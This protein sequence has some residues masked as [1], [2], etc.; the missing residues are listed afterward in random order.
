MEY[1][2]DL[3][4]S[5]IHL[6]SS[7]SDVEKFSYLLSL[8]ESS[9]LEAVSGLS[10]TTANYAEAISVLNRRFGKKHS[11]VSKRMKVLMGFESISSDLNV[12]GLRRLFDTVESQVRGLRTLG[13]TAESYGG[14]LSSL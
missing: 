8:L 14:L 3:F 12:K 7:L 9:A 2:W 1:I 13:I 10:L 6:N 11:I 4:E 5:S